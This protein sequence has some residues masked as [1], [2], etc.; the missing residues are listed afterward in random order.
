[1]GLLKMVVPEICRATVHMYGI[2]AQR[3]CPWIISPCKMDIL[4]KYIDRHL[5][6]VLSPWSII[7]INSSH[8][9]Q[10]GIPGLTDNG[11]STVCMDCVVRLVGKCLTLHSQT[12]AWLGTFNVGTLEKW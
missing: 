8:H 5:M 7:R 9:F 3:H 2:L 6:Y 11:L 10:L 12:C 4:E 1:M